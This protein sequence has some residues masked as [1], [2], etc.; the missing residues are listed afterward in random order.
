MKKNQKKNYFIIIVAGKLPSSTS[1]NSLKVSQEITH[2]KA[3][4]NDLE[5]YMEMLYED[6]PEK[7]EGAARVLQ[8]ARNP[9]FL[10]ELCH[11][12]LYL[13]FFLLIVIVYLLIFYI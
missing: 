7:I 6:I 12:G 1:T 3:S 11:N 8:L 10:E 9:D 4:L 2:Q 5:T 13:I